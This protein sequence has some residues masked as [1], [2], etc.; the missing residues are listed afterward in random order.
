MIDQEIKDL[1]IS[2]QEWDSWNPMN[3]EDNIDDS[4]RF[5]DCTWVLG[6][7]TAGHGGSICLIRDQQVVFFLKEERVSRLKRDC[8]FPFRA[9][10]EV[11]KYTDE[12]DLVVFSILLNLKE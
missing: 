12:L 5:G 3:Q 4:V 10:Q 11:K 6:I 2:D 1:M 8:D 7:S 9:I